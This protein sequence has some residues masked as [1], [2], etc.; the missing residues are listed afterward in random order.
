MIQYF[1]IWVVLTVLGLDPLALW[2]SFQNA[3]G[4]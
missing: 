2:Q 1:W 4:A 3:F